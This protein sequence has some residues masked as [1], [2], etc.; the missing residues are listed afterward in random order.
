MEAHQ[1]NDILYNMAKISEVEQVEQPCGDVVISIK[2]MM[3][4]L[5]PP[6]F[7]CSI[8]RVPKLLRKMNNAAYTP[9]V[10]SIGPFHHRRKDLIA[11]E[12]YKLRRCVD[13][14][15]RLDNKMNSLELLVK[16]TQNWVKNA[17][18]YYAEPIHMC[19]KDFHK[20]ML[21]D[22][23]FILEF[24]IQHHDQCLSNVSSETQNNLDLSFHQRYHEI[25]TDLVMLENQV[26]FFVLQSLFH[27][28]PQNKTSIPFLTLTHEFLL[29]RLVNYSLF[30]SSLTK[31]KH[32]VDF[33]SFYFVVD[34][35]SP[36]DNKNNY[37]LRTPPS[38]TELYEAGVTIK[39]AK[40]AR[41][42]MDIN[43]KN[44][45]LTIPPLMIDDFF[46]PIM[47]NLIAFEHFPLEDKSKCTQYITFMDKLISTEKDV[48]LLVQAEIIINNI[49]G[50]D[51]EVSKLFNNLCKFVEERCDDKFNEISKAL[52]DH[53]NKRWNKAKASL[54]HN[55]FNTPWAAISFSA[56]TLLIILTLLQ[57]IFSAISAFPEN[58][59]KSI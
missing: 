14:L 48:S 17:R 2:K 24:L 5:P 22:G 23:C 29:P 43:F 10:I 58:P 41:N 33:L 46:E 19:D 12:Q 25:Y 38:I 6:N 39:K 30:D 40:G 59:K 28:I 45:I 20:M 13:F 32:F 16:A 57:T 4:Q 53:C 50:S 7:E 49:G 35:K 44:G 52:R 27:L 18:N 47:R 9:Q 56:A 37:C 21:V 36:K 3:E 26:P 54:K 31:P 11:T 15:N 8:Y 1:A 34:N 55:Y 51:K 42:M